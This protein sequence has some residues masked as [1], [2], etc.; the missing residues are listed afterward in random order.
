MGEGLFT[1]LPLYEE[2]GTVGTHARAP[3]SCLAN[4]SMRPHVRAHLLRITVSV[5]VS[6]SLSVCLIPTLLFAFLVLALSVS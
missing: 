3:V 1:S 5:F 6:V 2:F 4:T